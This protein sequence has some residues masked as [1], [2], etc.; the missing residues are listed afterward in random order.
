MN[1]KSLSPFSVKSVKSVQVSGDHANNRSNPHHVTI[2][3][4]GYANINNTS[5][6]DKPVSTA[7]KTA[8]SGKADAFT[9]YTG[10]FDV[11]VSVDFTAQTTTKKTIT[12]ENGIITGIS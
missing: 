10:S 4:L 8:L 12:V 2:A 3:Q 11:V 6:A 9:G 5:D 7:T 1:R